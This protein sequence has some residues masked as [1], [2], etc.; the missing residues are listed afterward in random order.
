MLPEENHRWLELADR[1]GQGTRIDWETETRDLESEDPRILRSL[2][3]LAAIRQLHSRE[4][5]QDVPADEPTD[6][7]TWAGLTIQGRL[8][9]GSFGT[10]YD[11][12]DPKLDRDV[13]LKLLHP[14]KLPGPDARQRMLE[15]G[16]ALAKL[17][18]PNLVQVHG[19]D[20]HDGRVGI[21]MEKI[22]GSTLAERVQRD[23]PMGA[24]EVRAIAR[25]LAQ[26]LAAVHASGL[27]HRDIKAQ[28]VMREEGGRLVLM[29]LGASTPRLP[30]PDDD[31]AR[32]MTGTPL[33]LAPELLQ[34][35]PATPRSDV[36]ALGV[37]LFHL[38]TGRYPVEASDLDE[39]KAKHFSGERTRV[40]D[41]RP[42]VD[43]ELGALLETAT[44][45][46]PSRRF[47]TAGELA[48]ALGASRDTQASDAAP[49]ARARRPWL[50]AA[51]IAALLLLPLWIPRFANLGGDGLEVSAGLWSI[52][53]GQARRELFSGARIAPGD[54]LHLE[55]T[56]DATAHVYV[57]TEDDNG[58]ASVL[59]P[60]EG[61]LVQNPLDAGTHTL[62]E[63]GAF[64]NVDTTGGRE[65][66]LVL[67]SPEPLRELETQLAALDPQAPATLS[68][69]SLARL[70]G[71][72][73]VVRRE[74]PGPT[75][76]S[77]LARAQDTLAGGQRV[78]GVWMR[79]FVL[80]NPGR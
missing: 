10:V 22:Q 66:I 59:F 16:R 33:Y 30:G 78:D 62:P 7:E 48:E 11:A 56:V 71:I 52:P 18:H 75:G 12:H 65:H 35:H 24:D 67:A 39:L 20:E 47:A 4:E 26:A 21:W 69:G 28:N 79:S 72:G 31:S 60:R 51:A 40:T 57:L 37:L 41:L 58:H 43:P 13:A 45:A 5:P 63:S 6:L 23:G 15:E 36:Y 44:H 14:G 29:D 80:E 8:G 1:I 17:R 68:D 42:D 34:G 46:D 32:R 38:L 9:H 70:R 73:T 61:L 50:V 2:R 27:L 74:A 49:P 53:Q 25:T 54:L 55:V 19:L 64:W 76:G 3:I 77:L